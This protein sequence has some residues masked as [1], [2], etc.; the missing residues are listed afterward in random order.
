[1]DTITYE[2]GTYT[3]SGMDHKLQKG[4][5]PLVQILHRRVGSQWWDIAYGD[6]THTQ[7]VWNTIKR[8]G[9]RIA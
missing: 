4:G 2:T 6:K 9:V 5:D 8:E 3:L 1:M 7:E